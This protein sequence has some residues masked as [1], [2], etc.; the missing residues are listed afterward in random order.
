MV[1]PIFIADS[2]CDFETNAS[3]LWKSSRAAL[4]VRSIFDTK[5]FM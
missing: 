4:C 5:K 2:L 3:K 1:L